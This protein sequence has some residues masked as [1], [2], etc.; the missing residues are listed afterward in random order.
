M[1]TIAFIGLGLIGGS[2]AKA[3]RK[4]HPDYRLLA[5]NRSKEALAAALDDNTIDAVCEVQD[6]RYASCDYIF[7]CAPVEFNLQYLEYLKNV[8][9]DHCIITDAGSVKG[10]IHEKIAE[11]G[12]EHCFIGGHP[13][14]GSER[15]DMNTQVTV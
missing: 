5:Y 11:L 10:P 13:M 15:S 7:L 12:M 2:I 8:I 14:A 9:S 4:Y 1:K 6:E 3:I